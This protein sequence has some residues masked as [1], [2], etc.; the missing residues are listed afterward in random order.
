MG[1]PLI[2]ICA[3][4]II[5]LGILQL[6]LNGRHIQLIERTSS[7]ANE[8]QMRNSAHSGSEYVLNE[9]R[10][11]PTWRN[12][13]EPYPVQLDYAT[14]FVMIQ[15]SSTNE[16]LEDDQLRLLSKVPF[17]ADSVMVVYDVDVVMGSIGDV[18]GALNLTDGEFN[19]DLFS[20]AFEIDGNDESGEDPIGKPGM[21]VLDQ[22]SKDKIFDTNNEDFLDNITG[23]TGT[24]SIE[25]DEN[26]DFTDMEQLILA[27]EANATYLQGNY[28]GDLNTPENPGVFFVEDYAKIA[29]DVNGY[30]IMV[31]RESGD[32]D[33][34]STLDLK[35][36]LDFYGLVIFEDAWAFD[37][38][39]TA[40]IHGAVMVGS[41]DEENEIDV[42]LGGTL[43]ILYNSWALQFAEIAAQRGVAASFD[44]TAIFE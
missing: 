24:P 9:L 36:T 17:Q 20:N 44:I 42:K 22:E 6:N 15:D 28:T 33:L 41:P 27:L 30:G 11:D 5:V 21:T 16:N 32:L 18:P 40:T 19:I 29:G 31:V 43:K 10:N 4:T 2:Y 12:D 14:A 35:G 23:N 34:E 7:Y 1:R 8:S 26:L 38:K 39:G 13:Y 37:G 3:V 25:V